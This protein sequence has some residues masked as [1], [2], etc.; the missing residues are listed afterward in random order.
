MKNNL[1]QVVS[2]VVMMSAC[3]PAY[4]PNLRNAPA[5]TK[6]GE[7]QG[8]VQAL[9]GVDIQT[10]VSAT[11]H[12]AFMANFSLGYRD[13]TESNNYHRHQLIELGAGYFTKREG[14]GFQFFA[15]YG[16]GSS[17]GMYEWF[18][19]DEEAT[20]SKFDRYFF[21]PALSFYQ[22]RVTMSIVPRFS[23][24]NFYEYK[25]VNTLVDFDKR[26]MTFFEPAFITNIYFA[27]NK[28]FL[29]M[30]V[31]LAVPFQN[32]RYEEEPFDY[33]FFTTGIGMGVRLGG[34]A[35]LRAK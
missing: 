9:N 25:N 5:F 2:L 26:D 17:E 3:A 23:Y 28:F 24:L 34:D 31:G 22:P 6:G 19:N 21:Q 10:A 4:V 29:T 8:S 27:E 30:Q 20:I 1:L 12:I 32:Y 33:R 35:V 7:F 14:I 11:K 18:T 15:G 16:R 13:N